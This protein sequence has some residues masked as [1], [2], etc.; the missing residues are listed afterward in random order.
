MRMDN[1]SQITRPPLRPRGQALLDRFLGGLHGA[2]L[3]IEVL[4]AIG[5]VALAAG[6]LVGLGVSIWSAATNGH[7]L[8]S[9]EF[10]VLIGRV[11]EVFILVELFRIT[12]A[13]MNH[14]NVVPTVLEAAL[15]A[16]ARKFVVFEA[17]PR[18][19]EL[20]LGLSALLLAVALA[21]WLLSRSNACDLPE[22]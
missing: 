12:I 22:D 2:T 6:A 11:L 21:W 9:V 1:S 14:E 3:L 8:T 18:A 17:S 4:V 10:N 15:V 19:F 7:I 13:Y 16:V 20:A 5:L